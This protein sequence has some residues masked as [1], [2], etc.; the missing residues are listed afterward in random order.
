MFVYASLLLD[1]DGVEY[2]GVL[3]GIDETTLG[4]GMVVTNLSAF[5]LG[6]YFGWRFLRAVRVKEK[7]IRDEMAK[8]VESKAAHAEEQ[9]E[10]ASR[11]SWSRERRR[12][13]DVSSARCAQT[14]MWKRG[15]FGKYP[16]VLASWARSAT[17]HSLAFPSC[18]PSTPPLP[19]SCTQIALA[20]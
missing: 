12:P 11:W 20:S 19:G 3:A 5:L 18:N 17:L 2:S 9:A 8:Q 7:V 14:D 13:A 15:P 10:K 4:V 16:R 6:A 1:Y